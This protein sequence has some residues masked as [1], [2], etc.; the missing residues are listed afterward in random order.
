[1]IWLYLGFA[2]FFAGVLVLMLRRELRRSDKKHALDSWYWDERKV[3]LEDSI[4]N[5]APRS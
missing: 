1:M 5:A 4:K 3:R 2:G